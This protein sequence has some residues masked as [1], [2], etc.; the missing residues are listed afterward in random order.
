MKI[1]L[2]E[3][4]SDDNTGMWMNEHRQGNECSAPRNSYRK[5]EGYD[6]FRKA[7]KTERQLFKKLSRIRI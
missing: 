7:L 5:G 1:D 3:A 4:P 2:S 6:L